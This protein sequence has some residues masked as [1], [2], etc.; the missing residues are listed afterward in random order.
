MRSELVEAAAGGSPLYD[1]AT[2]VIA[3]VGL[4]V[5]VLSAYFAYLAVPRRREVHVRVASTDRLLTHVAAGT[6]EVRFNTTPVADPHVLRLALRCTG[7]TDVTSGDF[8]QGRPI[9]LTF[10]RPVVADLTEAPVVPAVHG[11]DELRVGPGL[12]RRGTTYLFTLLFDGDPGPPS[13]IGHLVGAQVRTGT[14][15]PTASLRAAYAYLGSTAAGGAGTALHL[16]GAA[17]TEAVVGTL[18]V[19]AAAALA[20]GLFLQSRTS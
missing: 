12:L 6:V 17:G 18:L 14:A 1:T 11:G 9:V 19:V 13:A 3:V 10:A 8:D 16:S 7:R 5:A 20:L 15:R 4:L 2:L